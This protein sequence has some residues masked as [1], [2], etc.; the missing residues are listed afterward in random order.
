MVR[1]AALLHCR[2]RREGKTQHHKGCLWGR[3][4]QVIIP[5]WVSWWQSTRHHS[6]DLRLASCQ[7]V[8]QRDR[9]P[10]YWQRFSNY[11]G[12][13]SKLSSLIV[14]CFFYVLA[15]SIQLWL[16]RTFYVAVMHDNV[17]HSRAIDGSATLSVACWPL[18]V[19]ARLSLRVVAVWRTKG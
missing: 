12:T 19:V 1:P 9:R 15:L 8:V 6:Q 17:C 13:Q 5:W 3:P 4:R 11:K 14:V 7:I 18:R 16:P 2:I 10:Q